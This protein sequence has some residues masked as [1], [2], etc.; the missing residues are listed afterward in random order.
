[1]DPGIA[2]AIIAAAVGLLSLI[3]TLIV[4][5]YGIRR[6]SRD[7]DAIV[8]EQLGQQREQLERTLAEQ[9]L[10]TWNERFATAVDRLGADRPPAVRL[11][12]VYAMAGLADDWEENRQTC[13]DV[14]CAYLRMPY[15]PDPGEKAKAMEQRA[16][17]ANQQVRH[18]VIRVITA[19]L[20]EGARPSWRGLD[21]DF[22]GAVLDGGNFAGAVFSGGTVSFRG[23]VFS[24]GSV[25]FFGAVFSGGAVDFT[26]AVFSG[27]TVDFEGAQFSGGSVDF[28]DAEFSGGT[29]SFGGVPRPG[30]AVL[31]GSTEFSAGDVVFTGAR[32]SDGTVDFDSVVFSGG[33]VLF[34]CAEFSGATV[35]FG[36]A[37]LSGGALCF[38]EAVF[39]GGTVSFDGA[40]LSG[41]DLVAELSFG[42]AVFSGGTVDLSGVTEGLIQLSFEGDPPS[43]LLL[44]AWLN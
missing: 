37:K 31:L 43:G 23:A 18:T 9:R 8:H 4:Q 11:A 17:A 39:S 3:G 22:T 25:S 26:G 14:L 19:H 44:P 28:F 29:V 2:A 33:E 6:T 13:V 30:H 7:T 1:M 24:S 20:Q 36:D 32:F 27:G 38:I 35:S 42:D 40:K 15:E 34:I 5:I 41:G 16:F 21:L 12:A 10:R